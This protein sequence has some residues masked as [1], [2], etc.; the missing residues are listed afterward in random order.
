[1]LTIHDVIWFSLNGK[2]RMLGD[3]QIFSCQ[4]SL[5][6]FLC[7]SRSVATPDIYLASSCI[8]WLTWLC[9]LLYHRVYIWQVRVCRADLEDIV[10]LYITRRS[11]TELECIDIIAVDMDD[12]FDPKII[13]FDQV[14]TTCLMSFLFEIILGHLIIFPSHLSGACW[15]E[16]HEVECLFIM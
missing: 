12:Y 15:R 2:S 7:V 11:N 1:M 5:E 16:K 3:F 6:L 4:I 9:F 14:F 8:G 13:I 10:S